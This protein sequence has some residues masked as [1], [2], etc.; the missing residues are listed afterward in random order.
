MT[1]EWLV[2]PNVDDPL[3]E[4]TFNRR[5]W[6]AYLRAGYTRKTWA[7]AMGT[8]YTHANN[9]DSGK[10]VHSLAYAERAAR[11]TGYTVDQLLHGYGGTEGSE[12]SLSEREI[13]T[14]LDE[15]KASDE[16]CR[17]WGKFRRSDAGV[18]QRSTRSYVVAFVQTYMTERAAKESEADAVRKAM[19]MAANARAVADAA[20]LGPVEEEVPIKPKAKRL[21][22]RI[23]TDRDRA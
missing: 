17:A 11:L 6:A 13:L 15:L 8:S 10:K 12:H 5:V 7:K 9:W 21:P 16:A 2:R 23:P 20:A 18:A 19:R 22:P 3:S 1:R 4:P 14:V